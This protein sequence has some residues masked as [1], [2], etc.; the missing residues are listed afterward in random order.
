VEEGVIRLKLITSSRRFKGFCGF[1]FSE[2]VTAHTPKECASE[3]SRADPSVWGWIC[4]SAVAFA[5]KK[6]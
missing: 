1:G 5:V 6:K 2:D 3:P 4:L